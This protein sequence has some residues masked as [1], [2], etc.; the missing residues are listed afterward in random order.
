VEL[1]DLVQDILQTVD[2]DLET[3]T[4][5]VLILLLHQVVEDSQCYQLVVILGIVIIE[6]EV[7]L[8][9]QVQ[10]DILVL[11]NQKDQVVQETLEAIVHQKETLEVQVDQ[12][13]TSEEVAVAELE[14][15]V[16]VLV[17]LLEETV[18]LE[19]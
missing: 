7:D 10:E 16:K 13:V 18:V 2:Q 11:F 19:L 17:E 15:L 14:L 1:E 6:I 4:H 12:Q 8:E 3:E 5:R 9:D